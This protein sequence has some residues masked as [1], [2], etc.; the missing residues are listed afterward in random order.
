MVMPRGLLAAMLGSACLANEK[1]NTEG[2][3]GPPYVLV[4]DIQVPVEDFHRQADPLGASWGD[5]WPGGRVRYAIATDYTHPDKPAAY[6]S[7]DDDRISWAVA[8]LEEKTCIRMSKCASPATCEEP[9]IV[10]VSHEDSVCSS[11][12]AGYFSHV[13]TILLTTSGCNRGAVVHEI[14]HSLGL[15]HEQKRIDRDE[16]VIINENNI[17]PDHL[18][19]FSRMYGRALGEYD[20]GSIMH[21]GSYAFSINGQKTIEAPQPIGQTSSL[22]AGDIAAIDFLYNGCSAVFAAPVCMTNRNELKTY[23]INLNEP[24]FC[25][26]NVEWTAGQSVYVDYS[27]T[28]APESSIIF[29]PRTEVRSGHFAY[30]TFTPTSLSDA[31]KVYTMAAT[32]TARTDAALSTTCS[33]TVRVRGLDLQRVLAILMLVYEEDEARVSLAV[34]KIA[35]NFGVSPP[36][37]ASLI[38]APVEGSGAGQPVPSASVPSAAVPSA[39]VAPPVTASAGASMQ[40]QLQRMVMQQQEQMQAQQREMRAQQQ[41]Q[42]HM[43]QVLQQMQTQLMG[44]SHQPS[45]AVASVSATAQPAPQPMESDGRQEEEEDVAPR[46]FAKDAKD[47]REWREPLLLDPWG[48]IRDV[49]S[50]YVCGRAHLPGGEQLDSTFGMLRCWMLAMSA[51]EGWTRSP[52]QLRLG[53]ELLKQL[54]LQKLYVEEGMSRRDLL[55]QIGSQAEDPLD[56]AAAVLRGKKERG[57]TKKPAFRPRQPGNGKAGGK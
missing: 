1:L 22:S 31:D 48:L 38:Q 20:Y 52:D 11:S 18:Y 41:Q 46:V 50:A 7:D 24:F 14:C 57:P 32:F 33:L 8:H 25:Q 35:G 15:N 5:V 43:M 3:H 28:T 2:P 12:E 27:L 17:P 13:T 56:K 9:F 10:F 53:N 42:A 51:T 23:E 16:Y 37:L 4:G 26:F 54:R 6:L 30:Q 40:D 29:H 34:K 45:P 19:P 44:I 39:S 21:Y 36:S 47:V 55:R 49:E